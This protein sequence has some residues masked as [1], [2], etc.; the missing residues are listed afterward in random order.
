MHIRYAFTIIFEK[1]IFPTPLF[2][3]LIEINPLLFCCYFFYFQIQEMQPSEGLPAI[4]MQSLLVDDKYDLM[5]DLIINTREGCK[6]KTKHKWDILPSNK[7]NAF[8]KTY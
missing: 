7:Q 6:K 5:Q 2:V 3:V 1:M 4:S 8:C